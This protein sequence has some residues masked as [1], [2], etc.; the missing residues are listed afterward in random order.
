MSKVRVAGAIAS[1]NGITFYLEDGEELNLVK[2]SARTRMILDATVEALARKEIVEIDLESFSIEK[3]I[4]QQTK[5]LIRFFKTTVKKFIGR[6]AEKDYTTEVIGQMDRPKPVE[7]AET[8]DPVTAS[9]ALRDT[10]RDDSGKLLKDD[11]EITVAVVQTPAGE[12]MVPNVQRL[13]KQMEYAAFESHEGFT[14][15][16]ERIASVSKDRGHSV[17][18]LLNFMKK[19][20]L[21][22]AADGS[23]VAYKMLYAEGNEVFTDPHTRKVRQRVGA[24]VSMPIDKVDPS[25]RTQCSTGL[26]IARRGYVKSFHGDTIMLVKIAPEDVIA[27][28]YNEPDKM[29]VAG[30]HIVA[31]LPKDGADKVRENKPMTTDSES[32]LLLANVIAGNHVAI[33]ERV[34]IGAAQGENVSTTAVAGAAKLPIPAVPVAKVVHAL[35]SEEAGNVSIKDLRQRADKAIVEQRTAAQK[36]AESGDYSAALSQ[37]AKAEPAPVTPPA[38]KKAAAKPVKT[39]KVVEPKKAAPKKKAYDGPEPMPE[40]HTLALVLHAEGKSNR[41]IEAELKICRKTLKK[42]FDK[43]GLK[44]NG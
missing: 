37:P 5:G 16:M 40:K 14:K 17:Q 35:D 20:D 36:A 12:K 32:A 18:E 23:I 41:A 38:P 27:V 13:E 22:I 26:H 44:P 15:F 7:A 2:D 28:P 9:E 25:R 43:N 11:D 24:H 4:E 33:T 19:G 6:E 21:P 39:E 29:R 31:K 8:A 30:Y 34:V 10:L 1:Q 3:R 42:L